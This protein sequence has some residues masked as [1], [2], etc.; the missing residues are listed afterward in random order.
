MKNIFT[1]ISLCLISGSCL[2]P[3]RMLLNMTIENKGEVVVETIFDVRDAS[4]KSEMWDTAGECPFSVTRQQDE[5]LRS[6]RLGAERSLV[7][8]DDSVAIS[9]I[10]GGKLQTEATLEGATIEM[11]SADCE[12]WHLTPQTVRRAKEAAGL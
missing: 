12:G 4:A 7:E 5:L 9:I 11:C 2:H 10:W 6:A 1:V 8:L 3:G